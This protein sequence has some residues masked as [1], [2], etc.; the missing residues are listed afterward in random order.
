MDRSE[1]WY[2][3][4]FEK[5]WR[6]V[7][8]YKSTDANPLERFAHHQAGA[9]GDGGASHLDLVASREQDTHGAWTCASN[10]DLEET[11]DYCQ[12][13]HA[14]MV[15]SITAAGARGEVTG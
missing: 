10:D 5:S 11:L 13:P 8:T 9:H 2:Y 14:D 1:L 15:A 7:A 3:S 4:S 12:N 6:M